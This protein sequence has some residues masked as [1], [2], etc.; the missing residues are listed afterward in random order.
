MSNKW[1]TNPVW[2]KND[3][4]STSNMGVPQKDMG[5]LEFAASEALRQASLDR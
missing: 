2:T 4:F 1:Q 5:Q 3:T